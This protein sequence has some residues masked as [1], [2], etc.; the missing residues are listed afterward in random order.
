MIEKV[1]SQ[2]SCPL[3][4]LKV[5]KPGAMPVVYV[6]TQPIAPGQELMVNYG[7]GERLGS[8]CFQNS[9]RTMPGGHQTR[10]FLHLNG[11]LCNVLLL[12]NPP[13]LD[14]TSEG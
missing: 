14:L 1:A 2:E 7:E 4:N 6:A 3:Q 5:Q 13:F 8:C 9:L 12:D 11:S 10:N